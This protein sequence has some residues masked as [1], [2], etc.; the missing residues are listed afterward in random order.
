MLQP[1]ENKEFYPFKLG[2][3]VI[4]DGRREIMDIVLNKI[5]E[6][7]D[8]VPVIAVSAFAGITNK[9]E[10]VWRLCLA[11]Y[12]EHA[13]K[14]FR[15]VLNFYVVSTGRLVTTRED[16]RHIAFEI[17]NYEKE[18]NFDFLK[19]ANK[20]HLAN[21]S[22]IGERISCKILYHHLISRGLKVR[23]LSALDVVRAIP[24]EGD[25][26][27]ASIAFMESR[28]NILSSLSGFNEDIVLIEGFIGRDSFFDIVTLGREG[29]D[30]TGVLL[31]YTFSKEVTLLKDLDPRTLNSCP[32]TELSDLQ[33]ETGSHLIG[34]QAI[35]AAIRQKV[36]IRVSDLGSDR[37][38]LFW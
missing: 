11:G 34:E 23:Y 17:Y 5:F 38:F 6:R 35:E 28:G 32:L 10:E 12:I 19:D 7:K 20:S 36:S 2:G 15:E 3:G 13:R 4:K 30:L 1:I 33:Y 27:K 37:S 26:S 14:V 9:L 21:I 8:I 16:L 25:Y 18:I 29:S 24:V 22:S 31:A